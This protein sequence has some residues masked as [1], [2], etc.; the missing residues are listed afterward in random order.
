MTQILLDTPGLTTP[1][2]VKRHQ[3]EKSL[4]EDPWNL[5]KEADR[6]VIMVDVSDKWACNKLDFEVLKCLTQYPGVPAVLVLNKV[7]SLKSRL[8]EVVGDYS[9]SDMWSGEWAEAAGPQCDQAPLG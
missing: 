9:R 3:L 5:V 1:S 2:K 4:L 7:G 8:L 6:V